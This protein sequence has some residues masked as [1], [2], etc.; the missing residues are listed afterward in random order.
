VAVSGS[1]AN[2]SV[3]NV[4]AGSPA[5]IGSPAVKGAPGAGSSGGATASASADASLNVDALD[6]PPAPTVGSFVSTATMTIKVDSVADAKPK[7]LAAARADSG[8]LFGEDTTLG[9][10]STSVITV[11][12]PPDK[13][14]DLLVQLAKLG[15]LADEKVQTDD[16]TQQVID[17]DSRIKAAAASLDR[18]QALLAQ[19]KSLTDI[20]QLES[21]VTRRQADL[22]SLRGQQATLQAKVALSTIVVTLSAD[23]DATPAILQQQQ[24]QDQQKDHTTPLP[25]FLDGF[26]GGMEVAGKVG[27]IALAVVGALV[28]FLPLAIVGFV[29][30]KVVRWSQRRRDAKGSGLPA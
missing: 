14:A 6:V 28:P 10:T 22:E 16:V 9:Q 5:T 13:F 20:S 21:E 23:K 24:Q 4:A 29:I 7:V 11:K 2:Q 19:A 17:L 18:T 26:H 27:S 30:F 8:D 1:A 12:V 3:G 25:G 15:S